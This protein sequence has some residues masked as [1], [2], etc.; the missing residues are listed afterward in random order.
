[1][2]SIGLNDH[3]TVQYVT[4]HFQ[5][6]SRDVWRHIYLHGIQNGGNGHFWKLISHRLTKRVFVENLGA[7][8][9]INQ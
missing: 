7:V 9:V 2:F 8:L 1:M 3:R 4:A 5:V 6:K